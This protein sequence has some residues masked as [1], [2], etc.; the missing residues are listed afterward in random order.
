V[1]LLPHFVR[2][3]GRVEEMVVPKEE[4]VKVERGTGGQRTGITKGTEVLGFRSEHPFI[5]PRCTKEWR[6]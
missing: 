6:A 4:C 2:Q 1:E 5:S 3:N